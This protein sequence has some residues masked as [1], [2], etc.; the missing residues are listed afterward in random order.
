MTRIDQF[1]ISLCRLGKLYIES[2]R[3]G[4]TEKLTRLLTGIA[5]ALVVLLF[6]IICLAFISIGVASE[7]S[8]A[9]SPAAAYLIVSGFYILLIVILISFK[10]TLVI[11]PIARFLSK[12]IFDAP[13]DQPYD[14]TEK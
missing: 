8:D 1:T 10:R 5:I 6:V 2:A 13:T 7:I 11:N 4:L 3:I 9:L 12:I 14:E